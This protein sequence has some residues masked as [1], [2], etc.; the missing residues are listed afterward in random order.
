MT[1]R[2]GRRQKMRTGG[3]ARDKHLVPADLTAQTRWEISHGR[4][5][6]QPVVAYCETAGC[7]WRAGD[8]APL[9]PET[10]LASHSLNLPDGTLVA[11]CPP[12]LQGLDARYQV[13]DAIVRAQAWY[14]E[15]AYGHQVVVRT[16]RPGQSRRVRFSNRP[17]GSA[18]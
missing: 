8:D 10:E 3:R 13:T 4:I 2:A 5:G 9:P 1:R 6:T 11:M 14:H 18:A 12:N 16:G 7:R 15:T 17:R